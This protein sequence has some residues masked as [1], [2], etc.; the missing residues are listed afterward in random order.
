MDE[1]SPILQELFNYPIAFLGGFTSGLLKL[2]LED[3]P[4]K[5]WLKQQGID[6]P[7]PTDHKPTGPQSIA[8]E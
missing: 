7:K 1:L 6:T 2:R 5:S 3:D 4:L 8:I